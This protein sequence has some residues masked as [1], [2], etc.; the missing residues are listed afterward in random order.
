MLGNEVDK[1]IDFLKSYL[2]VHF[3]SVSTGHF[4][5]G[6]CDTCNFE[7]TEAIDSEGLQDA[8]TNFKDTPEYAEL[9]TL[10][11]GYNDVI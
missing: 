6:V 3:S 8:L 7:A 9:L 4:N 10:L 1:V 2:L 5:D 11:E